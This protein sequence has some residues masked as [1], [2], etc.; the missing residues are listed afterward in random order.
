MLLN[1]YDDMEFDDAIFKDDR[2][3]MELLC[4]KLKEKQIVMNTFFASDNIKYIPLDHDLAGT[5][6]VI[7]WQKNE[8]AKAAGRFIEMV[9]R[10]YG[11][12]E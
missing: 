12:A 8:S 5:P 2:K 9:R 11:K 1:L 10:L 3:F 7:A 6:C 4:K